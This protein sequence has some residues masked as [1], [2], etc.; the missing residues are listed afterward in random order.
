MTAATAPFA[1]AP[2]PT[3][4]VDAVWTRSRTRDLALVVGAALLT[5][6][7]AQIRIPIPGT[8]VPVTGQT[9][10]VL[11]TGAALGWRRGSAAQLL[12]VAAGAIGLP[13]FNGATGGWEAATGSTAGYLVGFVIAAAA[14]GALAE[15][16]Q[17]RDIAT[18]LPAMLAGSAVIYL[19]GAAWLAI[20]LD[21]PAAEAVDIGIAPFV[22][23]DAAKLLAAGACLPAAWGLVGRRD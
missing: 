13:V 15:R 11:V 4:I 19:F 22:I 5:A 14:V 2:A 1:P 21:I 23:G 16:H 8:P 10:A 3:T 17:D 7:A 9:F 6:A 12:Y 18:S 20:H